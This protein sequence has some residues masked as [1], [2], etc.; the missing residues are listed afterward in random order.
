M[1]LQREA[2]LFSVVQPGHVLQ[3]AVHKALLKVF[4]HWSLYVVPK[5][6]RRISAHA[7]V[8]DAQRKLTDARAPEVLA[9]EAEREERQMNEC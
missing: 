4:E 6:G 3:D 9:E 1:R 5:P 7:G 8:R 2:T